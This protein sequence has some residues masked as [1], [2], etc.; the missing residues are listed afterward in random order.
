MS[1]C[2]HDVIKN[3]QKYSNQNNW[4]ESEFEEIEEELFK[5]SQRSRETVCLPSTPSFGGNWMESGAVESE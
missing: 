3:H 1:S 5:S 2:S 4:C